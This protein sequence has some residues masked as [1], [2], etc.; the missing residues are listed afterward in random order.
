MTGAAVHAIVFAVVNVLLVALWVLGGGDPALIGG[1]LSSWRDA[2]AAAYWPLYVLVFWGAGLAIHVGIVAVTLP[3]R[4]REERARRRA[5]E[6]VH[7]TVLDILDGTVLEGAAVAA[8]RAAHGDKAAKRVKRQVKAA[9]RSDRDRRPRLPAV[10]G[11]ARPPRADAA[12]ERRDRKAAAASD[13]SVASTADHPRRRASDRSARHWVA[14]MFT[15]L[16]DSTRLTAEVGDEAWA[17]ELKAHRDFVRGKLDR[18]GGREVSTQG[19]GFLIRF[20]DPDAAVA[21]AVELQRSSAKRR[22]RM[23]TPHLRVGIHAGEVVHDGDDDDLIGQVVNLA[24]RVTD[25][26]ARDE[27]LVT[28][29]VVDHLKEHVPTTDRGLHHLKGIDRPRHLLAVVWAEAPAVVDL[30]EPASE[31]A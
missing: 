6:K 29:A 25:A 18:H 11:P 22:A 5:R 8:I 9:R 27:I 14:V 7:R 31:G 13:A 28:E 16:V 1:Y 12:P 26:A 2:R 24:A 30:S 3:A 15:D 10:T 21:C 23:D 20:D 19:D 17:A 4:W